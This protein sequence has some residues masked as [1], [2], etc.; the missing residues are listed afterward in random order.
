MIGL[1]A[2]Q[3]ALTKDG[4]PYSP[5]FDDIYHSQSGGLAQAR[6]VFLAGNGLPQRW[7]GRDR[8]V[9]AE[10]GF[11]LGLSFLA[12]WQAWRR[13]P[14]RTRRLHFISCELHPFTRA[15]LAH[16][17]ASLLQAE[18]DLAE[19]AAQL[20]ANWPELVTGIHRIELDGGAVTLTL[21]LGDALDW[22]PRL[23]ARVDAFF[24]DGF[25]PAKNPELWQEALYKQ[26][27]RL[28]ASEAT[29]ATY[30]V[31]GHVRRGLEAAGFAV[32]RQA[33]FGSKR[34]MLTGVFRGRR[35]DETYQGERRAIIIG[36]GMAGAAVAERLTLRGWRVTLVDG[37]T[38]PAQG[39][40]G[41][42]AGAYRPVVSADDNPQTRL[43]RAAF[44]YG[45]RW[46]K[47]LDFTGWHPSGA[48]QI[49]RHADELAR[50]AAIPV[51]LAYPPTLARHVD[52]SEAS[53]LAGAPVSQGG[54][55]FAQAG[56]VQPR[57]LVQTLL[58]RCGE[59]LQHQWGRVVT[60]IERKDGD[61]QIR[62]AQ[63]E[64]LAEA[65]VLILANAADASRFAPALALGRDTRYVSHLAGVALP[66]NQAVVCRA[67]YLTP[68]FEGTACL[69]SSPASPGQTDAELHTANLAL[70]AEMGVPLNAESLVAG[71]RCE[72]PGTADRLP[73][74]GPVADAGAFQS[75]H[76][77]SLHLAPR[78]PGLYV[79]S[80]FG[81]RGLVWSGLMAELLAS[82]I[83]GEPLPLP[84]ELVQA[85]DPARF[86]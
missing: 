55:W 21:L 12:T 4:I 66:A 65:P 62:D 7:Q 24:L 50:F 39:A 63:G 22:L 36:A 82:Q 67:G 19:L 46:F 1:Q 80:G 13:D 42:L 41:N 33:G 16:L 74:V 77:G 45:L 38:G 61:W 79:I 15:D 10:T 78:Q 2:A 30:T 69:G 71:R 9:I 51:E 72:R 83:E 68:G 20:Q 75:K 34:Q 17:H 27:T 58:D 40:S 85:V 60:Q 47:Q 28:A 3:L 8:F 54:L 56:W 32:E 84:R 23:P 73:V 53:A 29:L 18:P 14:A 37:N 57:A 35:T 59:H 6:S 52:A 64:L 70:L 81:A 43:A 44:L 86:L 31:A 5:A 11:G 26:F 48:L 25:S 76:A 49:A